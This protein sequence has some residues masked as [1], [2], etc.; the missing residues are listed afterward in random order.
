[1]TSSISWRTSTQTYT[2]KHIHTY[3]HI[4]TQASAE[5]SAE[6]QERLHALE[7]SLEERERLYQDIEARL[8]GQS[9]LQVR[10]WVG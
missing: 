10:G 5:Q 8:G 6:M 7:A 4:R 3:T 1:M 2:N 9:S